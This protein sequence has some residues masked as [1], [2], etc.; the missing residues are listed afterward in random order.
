MSKEN[1]NI[2]KIGAVTFF[3]IFT[4][5]IIMDLIHMDLNYIGKFIFFVILISVISILC[6]VFYKIFRD[7]DDIIKRDIKN[8]RKTNTG[9]D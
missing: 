1:I 9:R 3:C 4:F 2:A 6:N 8:G 7:M 5:A